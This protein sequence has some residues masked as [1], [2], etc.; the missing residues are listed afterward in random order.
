M[1][2]RPQV[3]R[4]LNGLLTTELRAINQ[5]FLDSKLAE[6]WGLVELASRFRA[7]SFDEMRDAEKLMDRIL[8]LGGIPNLQRVEPF[9]TGETVPEQLRAAR[10]LESAAVEQLRVAIVEIDAAGDAGTSLLLRSQLLEEEQQ[11][12]WLDT[13]LELI[14]LVGP[15]NYLAQQIRPR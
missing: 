9:T 4:I 1:E 5:Y 7:S 8:A 15:A 13:Q 14:E 2:S 6:H 10:E 12:D 3:V 11:L